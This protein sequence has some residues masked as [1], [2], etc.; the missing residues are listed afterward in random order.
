MNMLRHTVAAFAKSA[1]AAALLATAGASQA[2]TLINEAGDAGPLPGTA[3][4]VSG[5]GSI[6]ALRGSLL[7]TSAT[8][9][10]DLYAIYLTAGVSFSATTTSSTLAYNN[11]DTTLFLFDSAGR[12]LLASDDVGGSQSTISGY[13]PALSDVYYVGIAGAG[14]TPFSAGG[15]IFP[16]LVGVTQV[17]ATGPGAASGL[18]GWSSISNEGDAYE[19]KLTGAFAM[20]PVPEPGSFALMAL[21]LGMFGIAGRRRARAQA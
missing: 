8:D 18:T 21:G 12:G 13:V 4:V 11:F 10:A 15:A 17:S 7:T 19:I 1:A 16:S 5:S 14:Y 2:L 9:Y 3:Q 20:A 6:D